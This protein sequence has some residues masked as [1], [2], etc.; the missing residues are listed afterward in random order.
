MSD[1]PTL[2]VLQFRF[3]SQI[4]FKHVERTIT[5]TIR[6]CLE[7]PTLIKKALIKVETR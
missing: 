6:T 4:K 2:T 7:P 3:R 1:A 5:H